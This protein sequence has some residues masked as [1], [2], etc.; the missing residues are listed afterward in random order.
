MHYRVI[1]CCLVILILDL[2]SFS[3]RTMESM[4][5]T[6]LAYKAV[7]EPLSCIMRKSDIAKLQL[8]LVSVYEFVPTEAV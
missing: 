5:F 3:I 7:L 6:F 4:R 1:Q 2:R 8:Q